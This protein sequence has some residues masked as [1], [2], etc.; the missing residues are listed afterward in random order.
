MNSEH[1]TQDIVTQNIQRAARIL[2]DTSRRLRGTYAR[3]EEM[4]S[5]DT[6]SPRA[7]CF[8]L[9]GAIEHAAKRYDVMPERIAV[10]NY[11]GWCLSD[12]HEYVAGGALAQRWDSAT[13]AEQDA[14]VEAL[15]AYPNKPVTAVEASL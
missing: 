1:V 10:A 15:L 14:I 3:D 12:D 4:D 9:V 2:S 6:L 11:M 8:C 7:H 5:I 13:D